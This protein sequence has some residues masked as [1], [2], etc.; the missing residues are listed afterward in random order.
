M[1]PTILGYQSFDLYH[2]LSTPGGDIAAAKQELT[3]CGHPNGFTTNIAYRSDRP[4]EVSSSTALQ[5]ALSAV[6]IK[7]G[8]KS[9][10]SATYFGNFA[11][12][13]TYVHSHDLG[14]L[15]GGWGPDWPGGYGWGWALFDPASVVSAGNTNTGGLRD[16]L[17]D[18]RVP[19][20]GAARPPPPPHPLPH[21]THLTT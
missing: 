4:R 18:N 13:P 12:V 17:V 1:P 15:A 11:G 7:A 20:P 6:G 9:S 16:P 21:H 8:L 10:T 19:P 14:I 3:L 5:A 2:A